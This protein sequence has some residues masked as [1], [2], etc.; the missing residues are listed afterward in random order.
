MNLINSLSTAKFVI[1]YA[2]AT[3]ADITNQLVCP[4]I[5]SE[6]VCSASSATI[7]MAQTAAK[8]GIKASITV[9][10]IKVIYDRFTAVR[11]TGNLLANI[12]ETS[13]PFLALSNIA[14]D[15]QILT[16]E[17]CPLLASGDEYCPSL[18]SV[19]ICHALSNGVKVVGDLANLGLKISITASA[20]QTIYNSLKGLGTAFH[21]PRLPLH[22]RL[23]QEADSIPTNSEGR[24]LARSSHPHTS[25]GRPRNGTFEIYRPERTFIQKAKALTVQI[26]PHITSLAIGYVMQDCLGIYRDASSLAQRASAFAYSFFA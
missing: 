14:S 1:G 11:P 4:S 24:R 12:F 9:S 22:A 26:F 13:L 5:A 3:V 20:I 8:Y 19:G 23:A 25:R 16:N 2:A 6:R 21:L 10:G 7:S 17:Y 18:E 15:A